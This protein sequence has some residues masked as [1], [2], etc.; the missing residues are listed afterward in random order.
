MKSSDASKAGGQRQ[1]QIALE[2][3]AKFLLGDEAADTSAGVVK[4]G[5]GMASQG[6]G[7]RQWGGTNHHPKRASP[8]KAAQRSQSQLQLSVSLFLFADV[9]SF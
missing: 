6:G 2:S 4:G 9:V 1:E 8:V 5:L 3:D 7:M